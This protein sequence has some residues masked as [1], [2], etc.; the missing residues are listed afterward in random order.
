MIVFFPSVASSASN[1]LGKV[2]GENTFG[3]DILV[4]RPVGLLHAHEPAVILHAQTECKV[5]SRLP[6]ET[7]LHRADS[8]CLK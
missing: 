5:S 8:G 1:L 4:L 3:G 2:L 7:K 6:K